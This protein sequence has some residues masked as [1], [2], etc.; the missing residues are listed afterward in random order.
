[1]NALRKEERG[2]IAPLYAGWEETCIWSYL[3]GQ[4]GSGWADDAACPRSARID[5][6]DFSFLAGEP[7]AGLTF[8]PPGCSDPRIFVPDTERW[9]PLLKACHPGRCKRTYRYAVRK[10][11]C[12]DRERLRRFSRLLPEG[13]RL[14]PIEGRLYEVA[15]ENP[16]SRDFCAHFDGRED[17]ARR[18]LGVAVLRGE[19]LVGGASS[20]TVYDGGIEIEISVRK[21]CRRQGLALAS[22]AQLI[23][24]CLERGLYPSWDAAHSG[25][26][27]LAQKLGYRLDRRYPAYFVFP[28]KPDRLPR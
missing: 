22:A 13:Y 6:G 26:L 4:M 20:Y 23:L 15:M 14:A 9:G 3:Q 5:T 7:E 11:D 12:F 1:M 10:E 8:L 18:G 21:D 25:S 27:Q 17:Y 2:C 24:R 28:E 19:E 16:W